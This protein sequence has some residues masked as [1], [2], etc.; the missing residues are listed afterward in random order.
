MSKQLYIRGTCELLFDKVIPESVIQVDKSLEDY[1]FSVSSG[2]QNVKIKLLQNGKHIAL[3]SVV[4]SFKPSIL[5]ILK[6]KDY[7]KLSDGEK[8]AFQDL[9]RPVKEAV[10]RFAGLL[11]QE[12]HRY[13][14]KDELLG[15]LRYEWSL[16]DNQWFP[17]PRGLKVYTW[18]SHLGNLNEKTA[19]HLQEL[20]SDDE[21]AL[22]ATGY[23]HQARNSRNSRYQ[24]IYA[25]V[26]AELAVKEVLVRIE[27]KLRV[28]LE[29]LPSPP[30]H[31]LYKEV[32]QSVANV[33]LTDSDLKRLQKGARR[34]NELVHNPRSATPTFD[35]V[36]EY[37]DFVDN[38]VK[39][40]LEQWRS[41]N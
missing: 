33:K 21:E 15:N 29:E 19:N 38:V 3:T 16:G 17:T 22:V 34:R 35:E 13:D 37:I 1:I 31:K 36:T 18:V 9:T 40:L 4:E 10:I 30:L 24:W 26:A 23:L 25:T 11:K 8:T 27:P 14:I 39:W 2:G 32:L 12:L 28:I 5:K 20:I 7:D 6:A 41:M